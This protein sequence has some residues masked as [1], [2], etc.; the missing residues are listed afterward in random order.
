MVSLLQQL[1]TA[2][3]VITKLN[4]QTDVQ[5][6]KATARGRNI[7]RNHEDNDFVTRVRNSGGSWHAWVKEGMSKQWRWLLCCSVAVALHGRNGR[8]WLETRKVLVVGT[9]TSRVPLPWMG[10]NPR[11]KRF[12]FSSAT[13]HSPHNGPSVSAGSL[14]PG[15]VALVAWC[16][17]RHPR[18][19]GTGTATL[20]CVALRPCPPRIRQPVS[21]P[22]PV[23]RLFLGTETLTATP[24]R[25]ARFFPLVF[26]VQLCSRLF[27]TFFRT[28]VGDASQ[29][30]RP[31]SFRPRSPSRLVRCTT[32]PPL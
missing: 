4:N 32:S 27:H 22:G 2:T 11:I 20:R 24:L 17:P 3:I 28:S 8:Q 31:V 14:R 21:W 15:V 7:R 25:R 10:P 6:I 5:S 12:S 13:R 16:L 19:P 29:A 30:R 23:F 26:P 9:G 18:R 1:L